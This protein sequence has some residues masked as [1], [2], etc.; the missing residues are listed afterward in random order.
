M[1]ESLAILIA[2]ESEECRGEIVRSL[3]VLACQKTIDCADSVSAALE[4]LRA[5]A[6]DLAIAGLHF[7][8]DRQ[9]RSGFTLLVEI[10]RAHPQT[11]AI[12]VTAWDNSENRLIGERYGARAIVSKAGL[13]DRLGPI[14]EGIVRPTGEEQPNYSNLGQGVLDRV[15]EMP[16]DAQVGFIVDLLEKFQPPLPSSSD[17]TQDGELSLT[18]IAR[19]PEDAQLLIATT[20]RFV[21][22][23]QWINANLPPE[24][25]GYIRARKTIFKAANAQFEDRLCPAKL[26][27]SVG[28]VVKA[29]QALDPLSPAAVAKLVFP[30]RAIYPK[31]A[32]RVDI[33]QEAVG[34]DVG[35]GSERTLWLDLIAATDIAVLERLGPVR[36]GT[37]THVDDLR[38]GLKLEVL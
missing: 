34:L 13:E 16:V 38:F 26:Q 12:L 28:V 3:G 19:R 24:I 29:R 10:D 25:D 11:R 4:M 1:N 8:N 2:E 6:Y 7:G 22:A 35:A 14:V 31:T 36:L 33:G 37:L 21:E 5:R 23:C 30:V 15:A 20:E 17:R 27:E 9:G 18:A 32:M